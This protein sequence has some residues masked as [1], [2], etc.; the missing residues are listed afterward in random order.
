MRCSQGEDSLGKL[1]ADGRCPPHCSGPALGYYLHSQARSAASKC[2]P[3]PFRF[4]RP[5]APEVRAS[6]PLP[7]KGYVGYEN[8]L[9][10][11]SFALRF[12]V[13]CDCAR[14]DSPATLAQQCS[15]RA[16]P[17]AGPASY[18]SCL[19]TRAVPRADCRRGHRSWRTPTRARILV[20]RCETRRHF[21]RGIFGYG[22]EGCP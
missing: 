17:S 16:T 9:V 20:T 22:R 4:N 21:C 7:R 1:L 19:S 15:R 5:V 2:A 3:M 11:A 6:Q 14:C 13:P 12:A 18:S 10:P 8:Q